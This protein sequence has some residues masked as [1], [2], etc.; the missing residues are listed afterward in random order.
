MTDIEAFIRERIQ[1]D[2]YHA[3]RAF[4]DHNNAG[5]E[6]H[7]EWSGSLNI[8]DSDYP[9]STND[10]QVSRFMERF[11]PA[12]V[13]REVEAK[14]AILD[15]HICGCPTPTCVDCGACSGA[16]HSDPERFPCQTVRLL[17]LPYADHRD[18]DETWRP[19]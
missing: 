18:Y 11:D 12:R 15:E 17:A 9:I 14:R 2:E 6:W 16:H 1:S 8:G 13:L 7:E 3:L 4:G 5:P 10:S 19:A